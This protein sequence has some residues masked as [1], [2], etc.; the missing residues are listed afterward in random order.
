MAHNYYKDCHKG[1]Y[2]L[3]H[4]EKYMQN[5]PPP[6]FKSEWEE[7][8][9]VLCD[10]HPLITFWAY[11][12]PTISI[13]YM[14]PKYQKLSI[15]KPDLYVEVTNERK[16]E[17]T[18]ETVKDVSRYLIEI[19]PTT[20]SVVPKRPNPPP[21]TADEKA[22]ERYRKRKVSF[23]VKMMDVLVNHAKWAAAEAWCQ[24]MGV[25][26]FIANEK[27]MGKLFNYNIRL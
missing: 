25:N 18:G 4:P 2:T 21:N 27:N 20:Y 10:V 26:W 5:A 15:Y 1:T 17:T 23:E 13:A 24:R 22:W 9:F 12:P 19:K 11:E 16:D 8:M 7:K 3:L 14:T 6:Q